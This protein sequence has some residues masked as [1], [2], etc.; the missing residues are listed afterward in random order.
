MLQRSAWIYRLLFKCRLVH[1]KRQQTLACRDQAGTGIVP[2]VTSKPP[3][4]EICTALKNMRHSY[5][6]KMTSWKQ[7]SES[8]R[9]MSNVIFLEK[10]KLLETKRLEP[11]L[12]AT[13]VGPDLGFSLFVV[14]LHSTDTPVSKWNVLI[15]YRQIYRCAVINWVTIQWTPVYTDIRYNRNID[16][17]TVITVWFN[18]YTALYMCQQ[19]YNKLYTCIY[20]YTWSMTKLQQTLGIVNTMGPQLSVRYI[21]SFLYQYI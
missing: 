14:F 9:N 2:R 13:Y 1:V 16:I 15:I 8:V 20:I 21:Q 11:R 12:G 17:T 18:I 10:S 5:R 4:A 19:Y 6:Y 7:S 3:V